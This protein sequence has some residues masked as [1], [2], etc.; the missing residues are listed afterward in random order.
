[1]SRADSTVAQRYARAIFDL[2]VEAGDVA[3]LVAKVGSF[4]ETYR[5][6]PE[7]R[8]ALENPRVQTSERDGLLR[9]VAGR[10]GFGA[11]ELNV[12]RYIARR[13]RLSALPEIAEHL[14]RLSDE[15]RGV[16][17]ATVT[18]AGPLPEAFY[19]RLTRELETLTGKKISLDRREDPSLIAGVVTRIGDKTVDGS[20][21]GRL[22][23]LGRQLQS[24]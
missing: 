2:G 15:R 14:G 21:R 18:A 19:E 6:A 17:R 16:V 4:S 11:L 12:V 10:L 24:S 22:E 23:Q 7:F 9:A 5:G 13:R 8:R 1:M 3:A 20:L